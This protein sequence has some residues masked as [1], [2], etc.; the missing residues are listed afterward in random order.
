MGKNI[1]F[2]RWN[3]NNY[4]YVVLKVYPTFTK[5]VVTL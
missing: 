3:K 5:H 1:T 4:E 2:M